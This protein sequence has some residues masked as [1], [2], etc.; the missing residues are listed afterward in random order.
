M[1]ER[2]SMDVDI[3]CVGFGPAAGGFLSTLAP[4]L[5]EFPL[6]PQVVCYERADG[7]GYGVSG[8]VT[9]GRGI[10]KTFPD[11]DVSQIPMAAPV[12]D[13]K[14]VYLLDPIGATRRSR[15]L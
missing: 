9:R 14:I 12:R 7:L 3:V 15:A 2:P 8:V 6:P 5:S 11:L 13:E 10:R 1:S 4:A